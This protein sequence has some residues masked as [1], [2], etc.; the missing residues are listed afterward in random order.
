MSLQKDAVLK[1]FLTLAGVNL[2][3]AP[4]PRRVPDLLDNWFI[5]ADWCNLS[6]SGQWHRFRVQDLEWPS[7][8]LVL[9]MF[10]WD[11]GKRDLN[12]LE[13]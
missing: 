9:E 13:Q 2:D 12:A 11:D 5:Q 7:L 10:L 4:P 6:P 3:N 8:N 1:T